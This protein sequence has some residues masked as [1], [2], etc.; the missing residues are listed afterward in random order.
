[1]NMSTKSVVVEVSFYGDGSVTHT[2]GF[3][4]GVVAPDL[5]GK[6]TFFVH[7]EAP[8]DDG[9]WNPISDEGSFQGGL[10]VNIFAE[11]EGFRELARYFLALAEL[12]TS[13]DPDFHEHLEPLISVDGR[14]RVH[15]ICRKA[16]KEKWWR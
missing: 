7:R 14:T 13:S 16:P 4:G 3:H 11:A 5:D 9:L 12:D 15:V 6:A 10:Q 1:M 2:N 8:D